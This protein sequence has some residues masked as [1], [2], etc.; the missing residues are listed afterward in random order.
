MRRFFV[1]FL[2]PVLSLV[3]QVTVLRHATVVDGA[4]HPP[5]SDATI[6][7]GNGKI[8]DIGSSLKVQPPAGARS[9]DLTGKTVIP[10][11][12]NLHGHLGIVQGLD[13]HIRHYTRQNV[14]AQLRTYARYGVT[15]VVSLGHDSNLILEIRDEQRQGNRIGARVYTALQGFSCPGGYPTHVEGVKPTIQQA[16]SAT[17][18]RELVDRLAAQGA[19]VVKMWM[20]DNHDTLPKLSPHVYGAIIDQ[21]HKHDLKAYAHVYDVNDAHGLVDAGIDVLAHSIRDAEVDAELVSKMRNHDVIYIPTLTRE[22]SLFVYAEKPAWLDDAFFK[23]GVKPEVIAAVKCKL[24]SA[25]ATDPA[26]SIGRDAFKIAMRNLKKLADAGVRIGFG[27]DTGPPGRFQGFFEHWEME[28]MVQAGLTPMQVIQSFSSVAAEALG[29]SDQFGTLTVGKAADLV[30]L[31]ENPLEDIRNTRT[32]HAVY[33][34]GERF[35]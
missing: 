13:L 2:T 16:A 5:I 9:V 23:Q 27:T 34:G 4:G 6:V 35:E 26:A 11:I 25:Q 12:V 1:V 20:D 15:C 28:L 3:A 29:I 24:S 33:I 22:R 8:Q 30:V 7:I 31:D 18:A 17:H 19:D 10:G 14:E 21:A 32:I